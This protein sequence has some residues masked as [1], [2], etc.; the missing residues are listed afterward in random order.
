[1]AAS[2]SLLALAASGCGPDAGVRAAAMTG[3][4]DAERGRHLISTYGCGTCH[5]VPGVP[6]AEGVVG[7]PLT[8]IGAR[9]MLAGQL[10]NTPENMM[11]WIRDPQQVEAGTAM[12]DLQVGEQ[13]ARD[14]AAFL[15]TLQ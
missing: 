6:T 11:R 14:I 7:P 15:Y 8:G 5:L 3:G 9:V 12:P 4:G 1:M 13:D 10:P 2:L